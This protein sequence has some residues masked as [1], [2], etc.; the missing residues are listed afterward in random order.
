MTTGPV[1]AVR[2]D[3]RGK[4]RYGRPTPASQWRFWC[5]CGQIGTW[6]PTLQAAERESWT[7]LGIQPARKVRS[8][9]PRSPRLS[10]GPR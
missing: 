9:A 2:L 6:K 5:L 7:H 10:K 1:H 4:T 8:D 3:M